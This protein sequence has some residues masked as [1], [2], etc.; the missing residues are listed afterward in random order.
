MAIYSLN[1]W[2]YSVSEPSTK[3]DI[4][5]LTEA[6]V[7]VVERAKLFISVAGCSYTRSGVMSDC[8]LRT[9]RIKFCCNLY[10]VQSHPSRC[11]VG[12]GPHGLKWWYKVDIECYLPSTHISVRENAKSCKQRNN[13]MHQCTTGVNQLESIRR[14]GGSSGHH[15]GHGSAACSHSNWAATS[16]EAPV[17]PADPGVWSSLLF[18][19]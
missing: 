6:S 17:Q 2:S 18:I 4:W 7:Q 13:P 1:C 9:N 3:F 14:C 5:K 10:L 16:W 11:S 8:N 19:L 12:M 15:V